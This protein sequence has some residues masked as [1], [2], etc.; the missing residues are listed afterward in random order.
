MSDSVTP[1]TAAH[2]ASQSSTIS[3]SVLELMSTASVIPFNHLVLCCPLLLL[4]SVFPSSRVFS[5]QLALHQVATVL[6]I[7]LQLQH[8]HGPRSNFQMKLACLK[9]SSIT[10]VLGRKSD[11]APISPVILET[12]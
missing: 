8:Q 2:Q 9:V 4:P 12:A 6:E 5:N 10:K 7:Q 1:W 3:Q 11:G